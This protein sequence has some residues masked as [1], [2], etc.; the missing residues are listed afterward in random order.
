MSIQRAGHL[1][2]V[3]VDRQVTDWRQG[4]NIPNKKSW[5]N[6]GVAFQKY[7]YVIPNVKCPDGGLVGFNSLLNPNTWGSVDIQM[8]KYPDFSNQSE[9][10]LA[11][12]KFS[13]IKLV[14][15]TNNSSQNVENSRNQTTTS[16]HVP[17]QLCFIR[18]QM[19]MKL[20]SFKYW[21]NSGPPFN[22]HII[23]QLCQIYL[24]TTNPN[25]WLGNQ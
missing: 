19:K 3:D 24:K 12:S 9:T 14:Y 23:I 15:R 5:K 6:N 2:Q 21:F 8:F 7:I 18:T 11:A 22:R 25:I 1:E 20:T 13:A 17:R 10:P 16:N 4:E